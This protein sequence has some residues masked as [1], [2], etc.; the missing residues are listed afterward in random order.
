MRAPLYIVLSRSLT[1][2]IFLAS[3]LCAQAAPADDL[4]A[5]KTKAQSC[6]MCH[7]ANG[8]SQMPG[9]PNLAGQPAIYLAEQLKHYRSGQRTNEI[10]NVIAKPLSDADIAALAAWF[11]SIKIQVL[12]L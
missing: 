7:G 8:I 4:A 12:A 2:A 3:G 6:T 9:A 5:G 10:M 1:G 11:E